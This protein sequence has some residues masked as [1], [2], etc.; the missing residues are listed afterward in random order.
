MEATTQSI[1]P[2]LSE[3]SDQYSEERFTTSFLQVSA[4]VDFS[5]YRLSNP[6]AIPNPYRPRIP[7]RRQAGR[8]Q[9]M[10]L[11][12]RRFQPALPPPI[13]IHQIRLR[14]GRSKGQMIMDRY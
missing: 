1:P 7:K 9:D 12:L 6:M 3:Y 5:L 14:L 11:H 10:L 8:F 4:L 2:I 13:D